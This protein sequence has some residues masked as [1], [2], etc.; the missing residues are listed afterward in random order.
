MSFDSSHMIRM[1]KLIFEAA[2]LKRTHRTGYAFLGS[3]QENV[4]AHSFSTAFI[5]MLL[6]RMIPGADMERLV[7]M[8]IV[9]DLPEARTGDANGVH[10]LYVK[11]DEGR[12]FRD[13][14][15][16]CM[17]ADDM[18]DLYRDFEEGASLEAKLV[19]DADQL[20]MLISLKEQADSGNPDAAVWVPFVKERLITSEA[21]MLAQR[22]GDVHWASWW[23][24]SFAETHGKD[25]REDREEE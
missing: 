15:D 25:N 8:A 23:M 6:G 3:G 10:K 21:K 9:H 20:D 19:R 13:A 14:V 5:A 4:A 17:F 24:E 22:I 18:L 16:G 1:V 11:R 12:A 7:Q 2:M